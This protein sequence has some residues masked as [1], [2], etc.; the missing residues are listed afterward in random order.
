MPDPISGGGT[1]SK[2]ESVFIGIIIG[3]VLPILLFLAGWWTSFFFAAERTIFLFSLVGFGIGCITDIIVFEWIKKAYWWKQ[4]VLVMIYLF[5]S[6]CF[7][8]FFMG[9]PVFNLAVGAIAGIFMGRRFYHEG[10]DKEQLKKASASFA[11]FSALVMVLVS[12]ASAYFATRDITDT[13]RNLKGMFR[14]QFLPTNQMIIALIVVGGT[15]LVLSQYWIA[16]KLTHWAYG[17]GNKT[18]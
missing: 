16:K 15:G 13:A 17:I 7:F 5:Y 3:P 18:A 8:G 14:L 9:V 10:I 6:A 11:L 12:I 4:S 2:L 1:L